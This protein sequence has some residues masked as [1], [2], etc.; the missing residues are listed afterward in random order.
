MR[1][2]RS[3]KQIGK[4][5]KSNHRWIVGDKPASVLMAFTVEAFNILAQS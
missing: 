3:P 2:G 5:G 1:E 4:K